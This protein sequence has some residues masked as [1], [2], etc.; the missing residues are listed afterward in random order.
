MYILW[1]F[2]DGTLRA[3]SLI[4]WHVN[5]D[6]VRKSNGTVGP[7]PE[8]GI[9]LDVITTSNTGNLKPQKMDGPDANQ[10]DLYWEDSLTVP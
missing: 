5:W 10:Q 1:Q 4:G 8:M 6:H 7:A 9:F 2:A 3:E